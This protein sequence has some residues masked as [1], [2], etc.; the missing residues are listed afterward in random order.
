MI[1]KAKLKFVRGTPTR[2]REVIN[3]IRGKNV[4]ESQVILTHVNKGTTRMIRKVLDSAISNAKQKGLSEDQLY[5]SK[6][7][8][9]GG[10][11]MKR[12]R[13]ASFGRASPILK[14]T[15]H[16]TI[17]LDLITNTPK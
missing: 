1:A 8:A 17:E 10:P 14:R 7:F 2:V 4:I 9:D 11:M 12:W 13:A 16:L 5:V 6:I 3:L 15:S